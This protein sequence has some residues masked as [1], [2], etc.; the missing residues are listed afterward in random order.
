MCPVGSNYRE[1]RRERRQSG[2]VHRHA[3]TA[4]YRRADSYRATFFPKTD[5]SVTFAVS[6]VFHAWRSVNQSHAMLHSTTPQLCS[7]LLTWQTNKLFTVSALAQSKGCVDIH[8][9][10]SYAFTIWVHISTQWQIENCALLRYYAA[11]SGN[12]LPTFR[13]SLSVSSWSL[14]TGPI[15]CAETS[16]R[17][18]HYSLRHSPEGRSSHLLRGGRLKSQIDNLASQNEGGT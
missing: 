12:S 9:H 10:H 6:H 17:N 1:G 16:V 3:Y 18:Y 4:E 5:I 15:G 14:K 2:N 8:L 11:S 13:H 7:Q